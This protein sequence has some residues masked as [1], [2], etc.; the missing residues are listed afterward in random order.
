MTAPSLPA[1]FVSDWSLTG[2]IIGG[3]GVTAAI[4]LW[5][6]VRVGRRW[7][8]RRTVCFLAG[9]GAIAVALQS[10]IDAYDDRLLSV[11]MVQHLVLIIVAPV[12]LLLGQ[13]AL[14]ALRALP[15]RSRRGVSRALAR[16]G[17]R[18]TPLVGLA[19]FWLVILG[20]HVPAVYDAALAHPPL[21]DA[22]HVAYLLAGALLW[23][24]VLGA[25]PVPSRRLNGFLQ[26][27]YL[28]A[29]MVPMEVIGAYLSQATSLF[30]PAYG[31]AS[32]AVGASP[33]V[34]QANAGAIMWV[35]GGV[36]MAAIVLSSSVQAMLAEERRQQAR[37]RHADQ[38]RAGVAR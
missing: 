14:L 9:L 13:P 23:W 24:P 5:A 35:V 30:Y 16:L 36:V 27:P 20:T 29:A 32:R 3:V 7:P 22:E 18:T 21:H 26:L 8:L 25:D 37:D 33:L 19:V 17:R 38:L 12:L 6:A 2:S 28:A 10:G 4:Y 34:D 31:P 15:P 11:H 1:L